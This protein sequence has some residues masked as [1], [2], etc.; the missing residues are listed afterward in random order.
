MAVADKELREAKKQ[1]KEKRLKAK[2]A[3]EVAEELKLKL[4]GLRSDGGNE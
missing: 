2:V 4:E 1:V 3:E